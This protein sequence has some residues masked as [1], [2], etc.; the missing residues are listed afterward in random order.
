MNLLASGHTWLGLE[1]SESKW[2]DFIGRTSN[3]QSEMGGADSIF[4]IEHD[5]DSNEDFTDDDCLLKRADKEL[6]RVAC[7]QGK[8]YACTQNTKSWSKRSEHEAKLLKLLGNPG[9]IC[10]ETTQSC[11]NSVGSYECV[12]KNGY[13]WKD[14]TADW[15]DN[16]CVDIDEC[17]PKVTSDFNFDHNLCDANSL[18]VNTIG[19][20]KCS[21]NLGFY[22]DED[23]KKCKDYDECAADRKEWTMEGARCPEEAITNYFDVKDEC[24]KHKMVPLT[25]QTSSQA[26]AYMSSSCSDSI[27]D[28]GATFLGHWLGFSKDGRH[29]WTDV[30]EN[31]AYQKDLEPFITFSHP[32]TEH[33]VSSWYQF[34]NHDTLMG[35]DIPCSYNKIGYVCIE[36]WADALANPDP[37]EFSHQQMSF[38]DF[39]AIETNCREKGLYPISLTN[40]MDISKFLDMYETTHGHHIAKDY[41]PFWL[42]KQE[43][44]VYKDWVGRI[45]DVENGQR[46][47]IK[48]GL[49]TDGV[50][51]CLVAWDHSSLDTDD[52]TCVNY[53]YACAKNTQPYSRRSEYNAQVLEW[54]GNPGNKCNTEIAACSNTVGS[55]TCSCKIGMLLSFDI[56]FSMHS[57][58]R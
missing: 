54:L 55:Y 4:G 9:N 41:N 32:A 24:A 50:N 52:Q 29:Q 12:C 8:Y 21:C 35:G 11:T 13:E 49:N 56:P 31:A 19:S 33:C 38:T 2:I 40:N 44:A 46:H 18:C 37:F 42:L 39:T 17:S 15:L 7:S 5:F 22:W 58:D 23:S 1:Y 43:G 27:K 6:A 14:P 30:F 28:G 36:P 51:H 48:N 26:A 3:I 34:A 16:E 20:Y 25:V 45:S 47:G 10:K 57:T 53:H